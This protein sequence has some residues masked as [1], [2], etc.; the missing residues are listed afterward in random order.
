MNVALP[1]HDVYD[2]PDA[3]SEAALGAEVGDPA[4]RIDDPVHI[5]GPATSG[6]AKLSC[7]I[8]CVTTT[9]PDLFCWRKA[10]HAAILALF[11]PSS[12]YIAITTRLLELPLAQQ[13]FC[14]NARVDGDHCRDSHYHYDHKEKKLR[15]E[16]QE[17]SMLSR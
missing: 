4:E 13:E 9:P 3:W 12:T 1:D 7:A 11:R 10:P 15:R 6:A 14:R 2:Q 17:H 8:K 5:N 16:S